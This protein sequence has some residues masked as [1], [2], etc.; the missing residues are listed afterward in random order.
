MQ[1]IYTIADEIPELSSDMA[2][3]QM[4]EKIIP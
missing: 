1:N 4:S 2:L 3:K